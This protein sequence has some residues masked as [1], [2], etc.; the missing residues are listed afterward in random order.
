MRLVE[1]LHHRLHRLVYKNDG[2]RLE[3][4]RQL[5]PEGHFPQ[6]HMPSTRA[7]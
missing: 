4:V 5:A 6:A 3:I 2:N 7:S 1:L